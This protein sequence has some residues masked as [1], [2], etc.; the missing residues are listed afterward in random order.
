MSQD[1]D[2]AIL[3]ADA[4]GSFITHRCQDFGVAAAAVAMLMARVL[5][6]VPNDDRDALMASLERMIDIE[7]FRIDALMGNKGVVH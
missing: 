7:L 6:M 3:L 5:V 1:A 2:Q 4:A